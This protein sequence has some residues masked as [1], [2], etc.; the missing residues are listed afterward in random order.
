MEIGEEG[1]QKGEKSRRIVKAEQQKQ[2]ANSCVEVQH[3]YKKNVSKTKT[4][5]LKA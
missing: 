5:T 3:S 2:Q 4:S 1:A